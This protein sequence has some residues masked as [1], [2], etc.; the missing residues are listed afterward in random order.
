MSNKVFHI[1]KS[2]NFIAV[3]RNLQQLADA[4]GGNNSLIY[5]YIK[6]HVD[7]SLI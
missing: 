3:W 5:I 4:T 6:L 1:L 2:E 7:A